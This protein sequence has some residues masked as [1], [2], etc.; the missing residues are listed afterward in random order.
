MKAA[1]LLE[2]YKTGK[3]DF[4]G[5]NLR[6]E[7]F[8]GKNLFDTDFSG[9]D[10]RSTNFTDANLCGANFTNSKA[11]LHRC[12]IICLLLIVFLLDSISGFFASLVGNT[13]AYIFDSGNYENQII[14]LVTLVTLLICCVTLLRKGIIA[15]ATVVLFLNTIT[16]IGALATFHPV[17][18]E[19]LVAATGTVVVLGVSIVIVAVIVAI[20]VVI[21]RAWAVLVAD[22]VGTIISCL[23]SG[24]VYGTLASI[25]AIISVLTIISVSACIGYCVLKGSSRDAWIRS[26]AIAFATI[27]GTSFRGA[28]LTDVDFTKAQLKSADFRDSKIKPTILT[29]SNWHQVTKLDRARPG[30][31][32][33]RNSVVRELLVTHRGAS[34][35]YAGC[36]LQGANLIGADL[37]NA[38]LRGADISQATFERAWL[39]NANLTKVRALGTN[40]HQTKLTGACL[41]S[42]NIDSTTQLKGAICDYVYLLNNQQERRPNSGTFEPGEFTK[43][44]E[45]VL[46]TIDLIF[47]NGLDWRA[48]VAAFGK[49]RVEKGETELDIQS[50]ENKGDG[51]MVV[52][53]KASPDA[54]K[55]RLHQSMMSEYEITLKAIEEKY[56][57]QLQAKD[58]QIQ[59]Y[60]QENTNLWKMTNLMASRPI[61]VEANTVVENNTNNNEINAHMIGVANTGNGSVSDFT[62]TFSSPETEQMITQTARGIQSLL[63]QLEKMTPDRSTAAKMQLAATAIQHI[64]SKPTLKQRAIAALTAGGVKA[65]EAAIDHPA[66]AFVVGAIEGWKEDQ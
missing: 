64:E 25:V 45:E 13:S 51:V 32:I 26:A 9:A 38:D 1:E 33:L 49:V 18:H 63:K 44:F 52:K 48:F 50:I 66:A 46:D 27:G 24:I 58:G 4:R 30:N 23:A 6:G 14:G 56:R 8:Q 62:Q 19:V 65:F 5:E 15:T 53:L 10:I 47:R 31:T 12:W 3:R 29:R 36:N 61:N 16:F 54:D 20:T 60:Q 42:W 39:E 55:G 11:G 17:G 34:K 40:F 37:R 22:L 2:L 59:Q 28:N 43:L 35:S 57:V 21:A 7:N 41:E